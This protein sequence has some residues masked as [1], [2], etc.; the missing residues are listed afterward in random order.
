MIGASQDWELELRESPSPSQEIEG[1]NVKEWVG[2][3][4]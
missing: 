1:H 3:E 4:E 2:H